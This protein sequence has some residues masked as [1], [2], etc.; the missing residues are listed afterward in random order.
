MISKLITGLKDI[1]TK[2]LLSYLLLLVF[3][4]VTQNIYLNIETLEWDIAS[5]LVA[6]QGLQDGT[7]PNELQWESKGPI[8]IY[9]YHLFSL[10]AENMLV[11]FKRKR[12][13]F[14]R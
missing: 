9:M 5:Y 8:F 6:S 1:Y 4:L 7:L 3:T 12:Y 14:N 2:N 10:P 11:I 13:Q